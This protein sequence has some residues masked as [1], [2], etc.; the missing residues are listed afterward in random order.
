MIP[1]S[2]YILNSADL[3]V[4]DGF[5]LMWLG[6]RKGFPLQRRVYGPELMMLFCAESA[7]K[8]CRHFFYGGAPGVAEDLAKRFAEQFPGLDCRRNVLPAIS[9][10]ITGRRR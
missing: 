9:I 8:G 1:N 2:R 10:A 4:P 3:V 6:R 5:P 7:A